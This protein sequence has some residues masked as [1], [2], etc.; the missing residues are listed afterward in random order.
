[1]QVNAQQAVHVV[2]EHQAC[3]AQRIQG[4]VAGRVAAAFIGVDQQPVTI[5]ALCNRGAGEHVRDR[6]DRLQ[7][8]TVIGPAGRLQVAA[9]E[10]Q[11]CCEDQRAEKHQGK[12][13]KLQAA[14][15]V[16]LLVHVPKRFLR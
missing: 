12:Q 2:A 4:A 7:D 15:A 8:V 5:E 1:M 16:L 11:P 6:H 3:L 9:A 13:D 10:I 14:L